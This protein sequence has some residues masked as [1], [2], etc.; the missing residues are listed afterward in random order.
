MNDTLANWMWLGW[1][2]ILP[3]MAIYIIY[4]IYKYKTTKNG[5]M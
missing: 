3:S 2:I 4:I 5:V 1:H